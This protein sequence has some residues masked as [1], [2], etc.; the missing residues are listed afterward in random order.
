MVKRLLWRRGYLLAPRAAEV[1]EPFGPL[2]AEVFGRVEP[3][4]MTPPGRVAALV[5][6]VRYTE[7]RGLE[8]AYVECG[9]WRGGSMMA[10]ALTLKH[11]GRADRD[12]YLFDT[13]EGMT[14]P[15][16]ADVDI[17]GASQEDAWRRDPGMKATSVD[18][19]EVRRA[20]HSTGHDPDRVHLV[21]GPVEETLPRFAPAHI[22]LLRLDTDWYESTRHELETLYPL[23]VPGGVL[24]VDD[25]GHFE[26]ARRAVDE[27]FAERPMFLAPVDYSARVAVKPA[28]G[29]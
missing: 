11:L 9:V 3:Y 12:L 5:E 27:Y 22:A 29:S 25:Y 13:F 28:D 20:M 6:A 15:T 7:R 19:D 23:L 16:A 14:A 1:D 2:V 26:G 17:A 8:G 21:K 18:V 10:V 4:T 24:V